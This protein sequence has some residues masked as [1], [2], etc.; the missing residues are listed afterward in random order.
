M[1]QTQ[2]TGAGTRGTASKSRGENFLIV[3]STVITFAGLLLLVGL[4]AF[5]P[6][7]SVAG[8]AA[9]V[10]V[11]AVGLGLISLFQLVD[12]IAA[13]PR[14]D[15]RRWSALIVSALALLASLIGLYFALWGKEGI[16]PQ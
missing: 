3:V 15:L 10:C 13:S 9:L 11:I 2:G 1:T 5:A 4:A 7:L 12:G 6:H 16:W 14:T 8:L